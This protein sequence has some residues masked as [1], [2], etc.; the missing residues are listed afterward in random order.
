MADFGERGRGGDLAT[1]PRVRRMFRRRTIHL[2]TAILVT[3]GAFLLADLV[4]VPEPVPASD[5]PAH[6]VARGFRNLDPRYA[7][8]IATRIGHVV[9]RPPAPDRGQPLQL[10]D[11]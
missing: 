1:S 10:I 6:H 7:Y 8:S 9:G 5:R 4:S 2:L 3:L 11:N